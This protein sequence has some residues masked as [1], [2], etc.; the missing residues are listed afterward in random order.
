VGRR[1]KEEV[2][3]PHDS[4]IIE[5]AKSHKE[6][7][8]AEE[9]EPVQGLDPQAHGQGETAPGEDEQPVQGRDS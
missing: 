1:E 4:K 7:N 3:K 9:R 6:D 5:W 8:D 2:K